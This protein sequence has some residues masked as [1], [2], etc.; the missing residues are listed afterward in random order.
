MSFLSRRA[1]NSHTLL[2]AL[3]GGTKSFAKLYGIDCKVLICLQR[4]ESMGSELYVSTV[5][6]PSIS[7][8]IELVEM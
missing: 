4:A 8:R 6:D 5:W 1:I 7:K 2:V 3:A